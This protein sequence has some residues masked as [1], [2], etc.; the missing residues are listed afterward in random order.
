MNDPAKTR[1]ILLNVLRIG[2]IVIMVIGLVIWRKG[3]GGY[4]DDLVGKALFVIGLFEALLLPA[5]LRR[6]WRSRDTEA[7]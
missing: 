4:Q 1:W 2:G 5:M 3:I 7:R 6:A